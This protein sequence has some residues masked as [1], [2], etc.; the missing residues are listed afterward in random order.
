M[1]RMFRSRVAFFVV[2]AVL[3]CQGGCSSIN[4]YVQNGFKVGP[5]YTPATA[6]VAEHWVDSADVRVRSGAADLSHWWTVFNDPVLTDLINTAYRQNLSIKQSGTRV[7]QAQAKLAIAKGSF[8]PQVQQLLGGYTRDA[9]GVG[10]APT[11][12]PTASGSFFDSWDSKLNLSW[13]LDI[14][15]RLSPEYRLLAGDLGR[16]GRGLRRQRGPGLGRWRN[17]CGHCGRW[18]CSEQW[19]HGC[20]RFLRG[21]PAGPGANRTGPG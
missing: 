18:G 17:R 16:R 20:G 12:N 14:W 21:D 2:A 6:Q 11:P 13:E 10:G 1:H 19:K 8:F 7:T 4:Q 15:V 3:L 5:N 9:V